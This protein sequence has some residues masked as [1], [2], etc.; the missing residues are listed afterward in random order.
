MTSRKRSLS[1][2]N[3]GRKRVELCDA[4]ETEQSLKRIAALFPSHRYRSL[5]AI[6]WK[7]QLYAFCKNRTAVDKGLNTLCEKGKIRFFNLGSTVNSNE[8]AVLLLDDYETFIRNNCQSNLLEKFFKMVKES[9]QMTFTTSQ[10]KEEY[11]FT[12]NNI[13]ELIRNGL[14]AVHRTVG[15]WLL[16]LPSCGNFVKEFITG[17]KAL[18][19]YIRRAKFSEILKNELEKKKIPKV[20]LNLEYHILDIVGSDSVQ[21]IESPTGLVLRV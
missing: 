17:R 18:I 5:P 6:V 3:D 14:L 4:D 21:C 11:G 9:P 8:I 10:L 12:E 15:F 13:S 1:P 2:Q 16:S 20:T 7:H 19:S